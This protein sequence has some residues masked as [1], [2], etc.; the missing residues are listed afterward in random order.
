MINGAITST[1]PHKR[2][3]LIARDNEAEYI[4]CLDCGAILETGE[5][6]T[7]PADAP[8]NTATTGSPAENGAPAERDSVDESLSDA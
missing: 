2:T 3:Q 1:C 7:Q 8:P 6:A 5:L 4:E